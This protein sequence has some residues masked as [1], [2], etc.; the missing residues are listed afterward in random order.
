ME[1]EAKDDL[2]V[3][4][5]H[6]L[7][8]YS[9]KGGFFQWCQAC[10]EERLR[11]K[12]KKKY[13]AKGTSYLPSGRGLTILDDEEDRLARQEEVDLQ[14]VPVMDIED[15]TLSPVLS[16][17]KEPSETPARATRDEA[18]VF[19]RR[20]VLGATLGEM[21]LSSVDD[22]LFR[23]PFDVEARALKILGDLLP[24]K[25]RRLRESHALGLT[26]PLDKEG[27]GSV[28]L[29]LLEF[30]PDV[31]IISEEEH[32][33]VIAAGKSPEESG[34]PQITRETWKYLEESLEG[35]ASEAWS[36]AGEEPGAEALQKR[37]EEATMGLLEEL[38]AATLEL[39]SAKEAIMELLT[40][41]DTT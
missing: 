1:D 39:R 19:V 21:S 6:N 41:L 16:S 10:E 26:A 36:M 30:L 11:K 29:M 35:I 24:V 27:Q 18:W 7:R 22:E 8:W 15:D 4:Q 31:H 3:F 14:L 32:W 23:C 34:V 25:S 5:S 37:A 13:L 12:K 40:K 20:G 9:S 33:K 17:K 28:E 38:D 2:R